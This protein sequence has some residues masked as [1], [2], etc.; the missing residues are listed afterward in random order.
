MDSLTMDIIMEIAVR[1]NNSDL[2]SFSNTNK[3]IKRYLDNNDNFWYHKFRH[4]Y[5]VVPNYSGSWQ[6]LYSNYNNAYG[7]GKNTSRQLTVWG[8]VYFETPF[9]IINGKPKFINTREGYTVIVDLDGNLYSLGNGS[10]LDGINTP[11]PVN[12]VSIEPNDYCSI[13]LSITD[14]YGNLYSYEGFIGEYNGPVRIAD[15]SA[16]FVTSGDA[17]TLIIDADNHAILKIGDSIDDTIPPGFK[18]SMISSGLWHFLIMDFKGQV[19]IYDF[20][21]YRSDL[22]G[23]STNSLTLLPNITAKYI[24]C[25]EHH[26]AIIDINDNLYTFG[27]GEDYKLGTRSENDVNKPRIV[28]NIK[29]KQVSCGTNNTA[30]IDLD[31]NVWIVGVLGKKT[32]REFTMIPNVKASQISCGDGNIVFIGNI[33]KSDN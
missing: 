15:I 14:I 18:A 22:L 33:I 12:T 16:K 28:P 30:V 3:K 21:E 27:S 10:T 19:Y 9:K 29:C 32:Y 8:D 17:F 31:D 1:L 25:G 23:Y 24:T 6:E 26:S 7:L 20:N 4:D 13:I 5:R 11:H 2:E